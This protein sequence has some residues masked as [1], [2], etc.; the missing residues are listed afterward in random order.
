MISACVLFTPFHVGGAVALWLVRLTP[1]RALWFQGL[2][3]DIVLCLWVRYFTLT[4]ALSTLVY[5]WILV[6]SL[7]GLT[8]RCTSISSNGE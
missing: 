2:A 3:G 1:G 4:V 7:Q 5:K 6:N 8:L